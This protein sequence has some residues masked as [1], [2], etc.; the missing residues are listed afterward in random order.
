[1]STVVPPTDLRLSR[2]LRVLHSV[3]CTRVLFVIFRSR[4]VDEINSALSWETRWP[5]HESIIIYRV[6]QKYLLWDIFRVKLQYMIPSLPLPWPKQSPIKEVSWPLVAY[7]SYKCSDKDLEGID[8]TKPRI[9]PIAWQWSLL[10]SRFGSL[11]QCWAP[12]V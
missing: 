3:L 8:L 12:Q 2:P 7:L 11:S 5:K 1:M 9:Q 10:A 6:I 4:C